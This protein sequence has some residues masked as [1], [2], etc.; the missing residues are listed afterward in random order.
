MP[1]RLPLR[2]VRDGE[3]KAPP[4]DRSAG[5]SLMLCHRSDVSRPPSLKPISQCQELNHL[6]LCKNDPPKINPV[7]MQVPQMQQM[8]MQ[9]YP[10]QQMQQPVININVGPPQQQQ[11]PQPGY[12]PGGY[13]PQ[14][15][16]P[17]Q[18]QPYGAALSP[19]CKAASAAVTASR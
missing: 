7:G 19:L 4:P 6:E 15:G 1:H 16:Y 2:A 10:P 17:P 14:P 8:Q 5:F 12:N 3:R 18:Q 11:Y 9:Q 13:P